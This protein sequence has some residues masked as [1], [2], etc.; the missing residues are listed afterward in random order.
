VVTG[1]QRKLYFTQGH[2]EHD[3]TSAEREGY[4]GV[5][6]AL[7]KENYTVDKLVLAQAGSVP[8]DASVVVV[9]GP[10][11][12]FF[13]PEVNAVKKYL[14]KGGNLLLEVDPP[15]R[16]DSPPLNNLIALTDDGGVDLGND[17]VVNVSGMGR[18]I[19]A[20]EAVRVAAP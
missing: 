17:I 13:P 4:N 14:A 18:L 5:T 9:A 2:A 19:G 1:Q 20:S 16:P 3:T 6:T 15:D 8:D 11:T 10:R 7:G 12:D